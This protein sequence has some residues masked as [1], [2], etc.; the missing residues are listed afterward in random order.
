MN[1]AKQTESKKINVTMVK[2]L[3]D[4]KIF[5]AGK[6]GGRLNLEREKL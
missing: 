6:P 2:G 1:L 3:S 5:V 4:V